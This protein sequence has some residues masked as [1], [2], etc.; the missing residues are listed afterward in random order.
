MKEYELIFNNLNCI[1]LDIYVSEYPSL[2]LTNEEIEE[3]PVERRSGNLIIKKGTYP[4]KKLPFKFKLINLDNYWST[5]DRVYEWLTSIE[6][7]RL[8]YDRQD[9]CYRVKN[10]DIGNLKKEL[11][12]YG[13]FDI[14]FTCEPFLEDLNSTSILIAKNNF[15]VVCDGNMGAETLFKIYGNGNIQL[16]VDGET[17][18]I[19]NV[20]NYIEVDSKRMQVRNADGSS[21][22]NDTTGNFIT[23][24]KGINT[25]SWVGNVTKIELEFTNLYR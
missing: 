19:N 14:T 20:S 24:T 17:M 13:E 4:D 1:D 23:L 22:D 5:I 25:I 15:N 11:M 2:T 12:L 7:N 10:V 21:K 3:V 9:R 18:A 6:D 16:T 8:L